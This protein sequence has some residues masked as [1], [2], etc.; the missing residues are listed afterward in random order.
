[1][2]TTTRGVPQGT[3]SR[4]QSSFSIPIDTAR[5]VES[6]GSVDGVLIS[7]A[8]GDEVEDDY[9]PSANIL[10]SWRLPPE[11]TPAESYALL[12]DYMLVD[13][14]GNA[15]HGESKIP[16]SELFERFL[17]SG[18]VRAASA[19]PMWRQ[20]A[21]ALRRPLIP[22]FEGCEDGRDD[23]LTCVH[24]A[25]SGGEPGAAVFRLR[26]KYFGYALSID[27]IVTRFPTGGETTT[28]EAQLEVQTDSDALFV[29]ANLDTIEPQVRNVAMTLD[30][31]SPVVGP[32]YL[33][34]PERGIPN[35][36][37]CRAD[38][39]AWISAA[40]AAGMSERDIGYATA[41]REWLQF[42]AFS[43]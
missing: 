17:T 9:P 19:P 15:W 22:R 1:M 35:G 3:V 16:A 42:R 12:C 18:L 41:P 43:G 14:D 10:A 29:A 21:P 2:T 28:H 24:Y 27:E 6:D 39:D 33:P 32:L 34:G 26:L 40:V 30:R 20:T 36:P 13:A 25:L 11:D 31:L 37:L 8:A 7:V 5:S 38:R 4:S 23:L